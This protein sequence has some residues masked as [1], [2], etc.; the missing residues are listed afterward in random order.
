MGI[1][2]LRNKKS[3]LQEYALPWLLTSTD[4]G[5]NEK[6]WLLWINSRLPDPENQKA[7]REALNRTYQPSKLRTF[8]SIVT[9]GIGGWLI[10]QSIGA[11]IQWI[12]GKG[13]DSIFK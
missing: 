11:V 12:V 8:I 5:R 10:L 3:F 13:L 2:D 6:S 7:L 9:I 4:T 1:K